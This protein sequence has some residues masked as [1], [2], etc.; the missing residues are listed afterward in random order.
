MMAAREIMT[1]DVITI[2]G[3]A[4][5][6]E[7]VELMKEKGLR[8]LIVERRNEDDSYGMVTETDIV[9]KVAAYGHDPKEMRVYQIMTKPCIVITPELGVEYVARLF[10]N[11]KIR[12]APVVQG[13]LLGVISISDILRKSDFVEKPKT[14]FYGY[15][16]Y[17]DD[18]EVLQERE[19][20]I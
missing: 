10:S 6:A 15:S 5:V 1:K 19:Y 13:R 16:S 20:D 4:T 9:Y 18:P 12:R 2:S 8:S 7:A 3:S 11:T 14:D 17:M